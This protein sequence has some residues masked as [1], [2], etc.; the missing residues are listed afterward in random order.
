MNIS[1]PVGCIALLIG[2]SGSG[3]TTLLSNWIEK[4]YIKS[5]EK[6][7]SD[8]FRV[9]VGDTEYI[10]YSNRSKAESDGLFNEYQK[11]SQAAFKLLDQ[12]VEARAR[13][14]NVTIVDATNLYSDDRKRYIEMASRQHVPIIAIVLDIKEDTLISRDSVRKDPRGKKRIKQQY[15]T[16]KREKRFLKNEGYTRVYY[17]KEEDQ[18][19]ITINRE[20]NKLTLDVAAGLDIIGDIHGCYDEMIQLLEKLNYK[21]NE[22]GY[23]VHEEGRKLLSIGDVMSRGPKSLV[24]M[25]FWLRHIQAGYAYMIDS[26][27]GWK[28]ARWLDGRKVTLSHGD[29]KVEE[30]FNAYAEEKGMQAA[31]ALKAELKHL[32]LHAPSH[33]VLQ[34]NGVNVAVCTHAGIK[35]HYIGKSSKRISDFCRYGDTDGVDERGKP[36]RKD[37]FIHHHSSELII[38][39]HDPK[40]K[41]LIVGHTINIDQGA[42]FGGELTALRFPERQFLSVEAQHDF[43]G[44]DQNP[45]IEWKKKRFAPPNISKFINGYTVSPEHIKEIMVGGDYVKPAIDDMSHF[46]IPIEQLIYIPPTMTPP[47]AASSLDNYLEHPREAIQYYRKHGVQRMIAEKKHMGS[48]AILHIFKNTDAGKLSFGYPS[49]GVIY[50]RAG[51]RFFNQEAETKILTQLSEELQPY[52]EKYQTDYVLLDA[53]IMPWNLKA[54]ELIS[55]QYAHVAE[56]AILDRKKL[57]SK[58]QKAEHPETKIWQEQYEQKLENA[59]TFQNVFQKYCWDLHDLAEISIA[60]FHVLAHSSSEFFDRTHEWHMKQNQELAQ[61]SKLFTVTEYKMIDDEQSEEEAISWWESMTEDGHEGI[62]I[63]PEHFMAKEKGK[64]LQPAIK[65]RGQKYLH[66]IYGIDYLEPANLKRLKE[67]NTNKK[68]RNA[69]KEFALSMESVKR[70]IAGESVERV[71]ECVLASLALEAEQIDPRL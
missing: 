34:Q 24:T 31:E 60:P 66:I 61:L 63:K 28:I 69:L 58:L 11:I 17:M 15:S 71:H 50:S 51:R 55:K 49:L 37:W 23:Y 22:E 1:F 18:Q 35:D 47:P 7:S 65:V 16:F 26:N 13:L 12:T 14:N 4:G 41:P 64:L 36:I 2:P 5:S 33:Y 70:F 68:Q 59:I 10:D 46:T 42:V 53:E 57:L 38:W 45:L 39:G 30:E 43:S 67:R 52:F 40:P 21:Q 32:L 29:E 25:V 20:Q 44:T 62:V 3:K 54:K 19:N 27:H 9:L 6:V 8:D 56:H 48:R